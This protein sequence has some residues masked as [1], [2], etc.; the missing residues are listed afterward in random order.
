M[1]DPTRPWVELEQLCRKGDRREL[2]AYLE[3]LSDAD[4]AL[5]LS[6]LEQDDRRAAI[7]A[8]PTGRAAEILEAI[9]P[10][11][12][13]GLVQDLAA[14]EAAAILGAMDSD[15]QAD[16]LGGLAPTEAA[17]ILVEMDPIDARAAKELLT[18]ESDTAGGLMKTEFLRFHADSS[19][20]DVLEDLRSNGEAYSDYSIQ[21]GYVVSDPGILLGVLRLRDLLFAPKGALVDEAMIHNPLAIRADST[22]DE[23]DQL[24]DEHAFVGFPV[25]DG[26]GRMLGV[27][28]RPAVGDALET[29]AEETLLKVSGIVGGEEIRSMPLRLRSTRR[30]SWLSA[31]IV[32]NVLAASVIAFYEDTLQSVIALAVFLPIISDM[33]GCSGSQAVT[34]SIRELALG[35]VK[36]NEVRRVLAKEVSIGLINGVVLGAFL[37]GLAFLWKG[38]LYL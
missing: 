31:N 26:A 24:F 34:V 19:I 37:G 30:L 16:L 11:Q 20:G 21:Y 5:A 10:A 35:L 38:N 2:A 15:D 4:I 9:P 32:L 28:E 18:Y 3:T 22:L 27:V 1:D 29:V 17:A 33:S 36:P 8:I 25:V 7:T 6:R 13:A 23:L 12:A 14:G